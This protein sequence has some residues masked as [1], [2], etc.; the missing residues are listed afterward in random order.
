MKITVE[1][2]GQ[3]KKAAGCQREDL[4]IDDGASAQDVVARV[5]DAHGEPLASFLLDDE[6][7]LRAT[8]LAFVNNEQLHW[9]TSRS[10]TGGDEIVF[11]SAIAGGSA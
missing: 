4:D 1:Y 3:I 2:S 11:M 6:R 5:A 7:R 9:G 8:V 10:L